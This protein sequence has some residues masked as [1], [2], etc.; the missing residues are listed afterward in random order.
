MSLD[1]TVESLSRTL[2]QRMARRSFV[3]RLG[4]V[5]VGSALPLLPVRRGS[6]A[7]PIAGS[8]DFASKAQTKD[9]TACDYWRY[10]AIDLYGDRKSVV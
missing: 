6:A 2:A 7:S 8:K 10:C 1:K 3:A 5:L 4:A 9:N